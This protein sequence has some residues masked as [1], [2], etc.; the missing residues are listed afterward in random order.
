LSRLEH[1]TGAAALCPN[2]GPAAN[3]S[4][5]NDD[6]LCTDGDTCQSGSCESGDA[7]DCDDDDLCTTDSC[8]SEEGCLHGADV[9]DASMC[10]ASGVGRLVVGDR[11]IPAKDTIRWAW[12]QGEPVAIEDFGSPGTTTAYSLCIFDF[13]AGTPNL[14][15]SVSVPAT[16]PFWKPPSNGLLRYADKQGNF[17]GLRTLRLKANATPLKSKITLKAKGA[18]V[19]LPTPAGGQMFASDPGVIAQLVNTN[20]ECWTTEFVP[21]DSLV[22]TAKKYRAR[23][24]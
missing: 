7:T 10:F 20:G 12:I 17:D 19:P 18:S 14:A 24:K 13:T 11:S 8:D 16:A 4:P 22:N 21:G 23:F 9:R 1:C 15:T 2:D 6:D 5:C 3:G